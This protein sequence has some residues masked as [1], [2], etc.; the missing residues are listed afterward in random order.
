MDNIYLKYGC[1]MAELMRGLVEYN[2]EDD[3]DLQKQEK[4]ID[5]MSVKITNERESTIKMN[6]DEK[7]QIADTVESLGGRVTDMPNEKGVL[8]YETF[9]KVLT[10]LITLVTKMTEVK[11]GDLKT[12][13]RNLL[14]EGNQQEYV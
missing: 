11:F 3:E 6:D 13:R 8:E 5:E 1:K 4:E 12:K 7:K 10:G 2:L 14:K 9:K